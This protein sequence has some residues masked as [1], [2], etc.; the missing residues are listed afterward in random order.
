[1]YNH[2][3]LYQTPL[4]FSEFE[5]CYHQGES[6]LMKMILPP[7]MLPNYRISVKNFTSVSNALLSLQMGDIDYLYNL[8]IP[9][10]GD[11]IKNLAD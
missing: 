4:T 9:L 6:I 2:T 1:M 8:Y 3:C 11:A 7:S 5:G 10:S